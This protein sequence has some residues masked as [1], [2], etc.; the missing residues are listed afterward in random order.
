MDART[1]LGRFKNF[2]VSNYQLMM[3]TIGA[4]REL[5]VDR[6]LELPDVK[7]RVDLYFEH[8]EQFQDQMK[9][10]SRVHGNV[11]VTDLR[12]EK[13]VYAGNRFVKYAL[14]PETNVSIQ[15][16]WGFRNQNT[17]FTVGKS[18][19]NRSC[20]ANIGN[21]MMKYGG[22]GHAQAGTCQI[23]NEEADTALV[24]LISDLQEKED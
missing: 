7:E 6:I 5:P 15:V 11:L 12:R 22:G 13:I 21:L 3:D 14:F 4:M 23:A 9:R 17:V 24:N 16:I 2:R 20:A 10:C 1:G 18:I 19:F 8:I